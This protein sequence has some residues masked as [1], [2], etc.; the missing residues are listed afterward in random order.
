MVNSKKFKVAALFSVVVLVFGLNYIF[1][2][3][4][5]AYSPPIWLA[6]F[7]ALLVCRRGCAAFCVTKQKPPYA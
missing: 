7:R 6:F 5:L 1:V 4:G 3:L 2:N